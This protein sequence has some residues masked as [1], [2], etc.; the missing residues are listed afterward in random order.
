MSLASPQKEKFEFKF[1][2]HASYDKK[3][4]QIY[5]DL[6]R[7]TGSPFYRKEYTKIFITA[8]ALGY[9]YDMKEKLVERS[10]SIPTAVFTT[11]EKWMMISI[12]MKKTN[13][14]VSA[15]W[16]PNEIL[17]MAEEYANGGIQYLE[18]LYRQGANEDP[19]NNMEDE[20]MKCL[21][22]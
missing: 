3:H 8:M 13:T 5:N 12:Y 21:S 7:V 18:M 10:D 19:I 15:L 11:E 22:G 16:E 1:Q 14:T 20:L 4:Y 6:T 17:K 9:K 2:K